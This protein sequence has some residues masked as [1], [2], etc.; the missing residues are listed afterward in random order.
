MAPW[1][2]KHSKLFD[3][4]IQINVSHKNLPYR[5][6]HFLNIILH[7]YGPSESKD[8]EPDR[9][10]IS[11]EFPNPEGSATGDVLPD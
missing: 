10:L 5:L 6:V 7:I 3:L 1:Y 4:R 9:A 2:L 11:T 8:W